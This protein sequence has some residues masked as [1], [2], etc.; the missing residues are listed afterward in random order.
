MVAI[1]IVAIYLAT[2]NDQ[3]Y[4]QATVQIMPSDTALFR[5]IMSSPVQ[6]TTGT[7]EERK[8]DNQ[9]P[10]LMSLLKSRGLAERTIQA[11]GIKEDPNKLLK[12]IEV[13]TLPNPGARGHEDLGTDII[14]VKLNDSDPQRA[15]NTIN[16]LAHV[17]ANFYQE[18]SHQEAADNRNFLE[19]ELARANR[20][21]S[22]AAEN[23]RGFKESNG[24]AATADASS[25]AVAGLRQATSDSDAANA[26][27][28][29]AQAK[30]SQ[31][32]GALR[33]V[34]PTRRVIEGT[35]NTPMA[36]QMETQL[37]DLTRQ[38]N[39]ARS[40]YEDTHPQV[41]ALKESIDQ[42]QGKLQ[43]EKGKISSHV[44][45]VR[46]PVYDSLLAERARLAYERNGLAAKAGQLAGAV[47]RAASALR[48]GRD[49][50]LARMQ[51]EFET[52]QK[53][54]NDLQTQLNQARI[55]EK[56]TTATGAM[57]I[58][59]E[60]TSAEGPMGVNKMAY[61]F[62]GT[63]LSLI[64]GLGMAITLESLDNSIKAN[65]DVERLLSL[66]VTALIPSGGSITNTALSRITYTDPLSPIAEAYRF[67]RTDLLLSTEG[68]NIR[69]IMVATAKPGQGGTV[70]VCNL[71]VSLAMDGKR[72]ILVDADMRRPCLHR[73]FKVENEV[74][75]S[76][77]LCNE[78]DFDEV[79]LSTEIDN[80]FIIPAGPTPSNPSELLGS[81]RMRALMDWLSDQADYV[82]IDT[83]SAVAFTDAV[84]LSR[85]VDGVVMV[86]RAQ[87]VPRGAELQVRELLN[88]A[89]ANILGVVLNDVEPDTVDSY[90]YHSH[91]YPD[92]ANKK[93]K[94]LKS[95]TGV[96]HL[97]PTVE[98][99]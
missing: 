87:Q 93:P 99:D 76:N 43:L 19:S 12:K 84:V 64:V 1:T 37:A 71:G 16:C 58:V 7:P 54:Y 39:D 96:K 48:P 35:S 27:L 83:P 51:N 13:S 81:S 50:T 62:M 44:T 57:R 22:E 66:P 20:N 45:L 75:L 26:A 17:F 67:L 70:T 24:M 91:Y 53:T 29:E 56:E 9:L 28:A 49:V 14:Q 30:L 41:I 79:V 65:V 95:L 36:Q 90:Y 2:L 60:A 78:K 89:K 21:L 33:R 69:T 34:G 59:D 46:D 11:A 77:A 85:I 92:M 68:T 88:K 61:F 38:L 25:S 86:V 4:Y 80:L 72:V 10:N 63:L 74:G 32:D 94:P 42:V 55:N 47:G 23:L 5:P 18:I 40:K 52:A 82:L 6:S 8:S 31:I 15:V 97:P 3:Q 73:T 98:Q